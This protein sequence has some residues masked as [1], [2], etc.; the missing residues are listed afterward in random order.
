MGV[1]PPP[2][3][4]GAGDDEP[5]PPQALTANARTATTAVVERNFDMGQSPQTHSKPLARLTYAPRRRLTCY[6]AMS[7]NCVEIW[8]LRSLLPGNEK[9]RPEGR[10]YG[11]YN[12]ESYRLSSFP[13]CLAIM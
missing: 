8:G 10:R 3:A 13:A 9:R 11:L 1:P 5:P 7:Q 4:T 6:G 12:G 2:S